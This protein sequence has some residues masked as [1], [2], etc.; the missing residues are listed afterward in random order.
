MKK[1]NMHAHREYEHQVEKPS[2]P[3]RG[4]SEKMT[5]LDDFKGDSM[6]TA[7]G[8]AGKSG[9]HADMKKIHSQF[10]NYGWDAN[11]GY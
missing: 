11:T 6:D 2:M 8:Q 10:K 9:V 1:Q 5:N 3:K 4:K 7:Y